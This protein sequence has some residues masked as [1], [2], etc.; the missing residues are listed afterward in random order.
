ML[1]KLVRSDARATGDPSVENSHEC[2]YLYW[3]GKKKNDVDAQSR[4][5]C[6][7]L[8]IWAGHS[9]L[10]LLAIHFP[11]NSRWLE[12][13]VDQQEG[14]LCIQLSIEEACSLIDDNS[15]ANVMLCVTILLANALV[16]LPLLLSFFF[17]NVSCSV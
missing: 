17:L 13:F 16:Q 12:D 8:E 6:S 4:M 7:E 1:E 15:W 9:S 11:L 2:V 10:N 3:K 5:L 14:L